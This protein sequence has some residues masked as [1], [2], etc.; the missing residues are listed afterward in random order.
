MMGNSKRTGPTFEAQIL[1]EKSV[2][3]PERSDTVR[4]F[5]ELR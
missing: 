2:V 3:A 4:D 5:R 1:S